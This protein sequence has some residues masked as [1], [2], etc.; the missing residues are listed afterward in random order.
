M[1]NF[2]YLSREH[3]WFLHPAIV[4]SQ[5]PPLHIYVHVMVMA[6]FRMLKVADGCEVAQRLAFMI[7]HGSRSGFIQRRFQ[8]LQWACD[9]PVMLL[10]RL[11]EHVSIKSSSFNV[12]RPR[13]GCLATDYIWKEQGVCVVWTYVISILSWGRRRDDQYDVLSKTVFGRYVLTRYTDFECTDGTL[14]AVHLCYVPM[15]IMGVAS[16]F[17]RVSVM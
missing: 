4:N 6:T 2:P 5:S 16:L 11:G 15:H 9:F 8:Y 14:N 7:V 3:F 1:L 13:K 10:I 17:C 12:P